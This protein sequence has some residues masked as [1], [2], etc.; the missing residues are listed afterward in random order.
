MNK[1]LWLMEIAHMTILWT[2]HLT[3]LAS[4]MFLAY[5]CHRLVDRVSAELDPQH[6]I[7]RAWKLLSVGALVSALGLLVTPMISGALP[8]GAISAGLMLPIGALA[9]ILNLSR[10]EWEYSGATLLMLMLAGTVTYMHI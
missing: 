2:M 5:S 4:V 6:I 8:I 1:A 7:C 10:G 9:L 3:L